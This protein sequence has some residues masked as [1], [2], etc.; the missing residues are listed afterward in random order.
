MIFLLLISLLLIFLLMVYVLKIDFFSP[1]ALILEGFI[2]S[3]LIGLINIR[4]WGDI[5]PET[6]LFIILNI[7]AFIIPYIFLV[8]LK[9]KTYN[10]KT[11]PANYINKLPIL[12]LVGIGLFATITTLFYFS[13]VYKNALIAGYPGGIENFLT[14]ARNSFLEGINTPISF[15]LSLSLK[16]NFAISYLLIFYIINDITRKRK[17]NSI[18]YSITFLIILSYVIQSLLSGGRTRFMFLVLY[19]VMVLF[20]SL[21]KTHIKKTNS[22]KKF[23]HLI[24]FFILS[25]SVFVIIDIFLRGSIYGTSWTI[26]EQLSRYFGSPIYGLDIYLSNPQR[27]LNFY[28]YETFTSF[29]EIISRFNPNIS[30]QNNALEFVFINGNPRYFTNVYGA[31]RRYFHDFGY[32]GSLSLMLF[33]GFIYTMFHK[34]YLTKNIYIKILYPMLA[35]PILFMFFEER[36]MNDVVTLNMIIVI[37]FTY[38]FHKLVIDFIHKRRVFV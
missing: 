37:V 35:Y 15:I 24:I 18:K 8:N 27:A 12:I 19:I 4:Q 2:L 33:F 32:L 9:I 13:Y 36:I 6:F 14:Y 20:H 30:F 21:E 31:F 25:I 34:M 29:Y 26:F 23:K 28:D 16:A 1:P 7:I 3:S 38:F 10:Q 22:M 17:I 5:K 11:N